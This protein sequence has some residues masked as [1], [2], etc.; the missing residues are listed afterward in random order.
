VLM[1]HLT[2]IA[3]YQ[4]MR[5]LVAEVLSE[6]KSMLA[7]FQKSGLPSVTHHQANIVNMTLD[8]T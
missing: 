2:T 7:V 1:Q 4:G 3:R 5:Q 6:N 8:L